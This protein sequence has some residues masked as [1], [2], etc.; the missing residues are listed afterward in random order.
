MTDAST[1]HCCTGSSGT[2]H[3]CRVGSCCGGSRRWGRLV[4]LSQGVTLKAHRRRISC[5]LVNGNGYAFAR[6]SDV[7]SRGA[8]VHWLPGLGSPTYEL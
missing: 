2:L 6:A 1:C 5:A 8:G 4:A 7:V 3:T